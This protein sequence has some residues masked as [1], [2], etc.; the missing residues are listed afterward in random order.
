MNTYEQLQL[1]RRRC[2]VMIVS[3]IGA[4]MAPDWWDR[5]NYAFDS[6][7]PNDMW[8]MDPDRVYRYVIGSVEGYW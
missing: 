8:M 4:E 5:K 1:M 7:T 3:M 2:E 6:E